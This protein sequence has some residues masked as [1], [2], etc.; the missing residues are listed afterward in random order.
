MFEEEVAGAGGCCCREERKLELE[1]RGVLGLCRG[2]EVNMRAGEGVG[3]GASVAR[4]LVQA[5]LLVLLMI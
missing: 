5:W 4:M 1:A 3:A 2:R